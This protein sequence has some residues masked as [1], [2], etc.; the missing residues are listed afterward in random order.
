MCSPAYY[1]GGASGRGDINEDLPSRLSCSLETGSMA[2]STVTVSSSS[3]ALSVSNTR[4][5]MAKEMLPS[6]M[7]PEKTIESMSKQKK[8]TS[9]NLAI[10]SYQAKI[11]KQYYDE[12]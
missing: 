10:E 8:R 7:D 9:A 6:W 5:K 2:E 11:N 3:T 1:V 4:S 12:Q